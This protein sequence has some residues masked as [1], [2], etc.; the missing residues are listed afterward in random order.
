VKVPIICLE[1]VLIAVADFDRSCDLWRRAGFSIQVD[2]SPSDGVRRARFASGAVAIELCAIADPNASDPN[3]AKVAEA[4]AHGGGIVGWLFGVADSKADAQ[5]SG[6]LLPGIFTASIA[7]Q[8]DPAARRQAIGIAQPNPNTVAFLEH[9][10]VMVSELEGAIASFERAGLACKRIRDAGRGMR[11]AFF[12]L[13]DSV[14]EVVGPSPGPPRCW[15][16]AFMCTDIAKAVAVA[17]T[18]GLQATEPKSAVQ[19]GRIARIVDPVDGVAVA[20]M[21]KG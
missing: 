6:D 20:F 13:E 8:P 4:A 19:G 5:T 10:V 14:F 15:G 11:Q 3:A 16:L 12:K 9:I 7:T 17:R 18:G 21:E 1:R 2:A